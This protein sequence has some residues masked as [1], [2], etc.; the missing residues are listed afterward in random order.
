MVQNQDSSSHSALERVV[1]ELDQFFLHIPIEAK[2][3]T[4]YKSG[5]HHNEAQEIL[6]RIYKSH[7]DIAFKFLPNCSPF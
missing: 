7:Q 5:K 6:N 2:E 4:S 1:C 3:E